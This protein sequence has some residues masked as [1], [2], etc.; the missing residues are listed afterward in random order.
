MTNKDPKHWQR[1]NELFD[2]I[3]DLPDH[4]RPAKLHQI[5]G[6]Y[7]D[8]IDDLCALIGAHDKAE[9]FLEQPMAV[10]S[11]TALSSMILRP[12][13]AP[14]LFEAGE[15][16]GDFEIKSVL[17]EGS[18][19][20]VYKAVQKSLARE[21]A[22]KVAGA[23]DREA[24]NMAS[25]EHDHIV[26]VFLETKYPEQNLHI[27]CMQYVEGITLAD[28]IKGLKK[29]LPG[30]LTGASIIQIIDQSLP[31]ATTFNAAAAKDRDKMMEASFWGSALWIGARLAE[32]LDFAHSR[33]VLH[34]D[35]KPANI[36]LNQYGRPLLTDFNIALNLADGPVDKLVLL[37]GT[38]AYMSPEQSA[39]FRTGGGS[40][41]QVSHTSDIYS[42]GIVLTELL[43]CEKAV[44][45]VDSVTGIRSI[46]N[47]SVLPDEI[48]S[49]LHKAIMKD[50]A[51]RFQS[52]KQFA[53]ALE[54]CR[55]LLALRNKV[56]TDSWWIKYYEMYPVFTLVLATIIPQI[57][58]T[59]INITYNSIRIAAGLTDRQQEV[60]H[61]TILPY[62]LLVYPIGIA[63]VAR[64]IYF[65]IHS[66][67]IRRDRL[68]PDPASM[69]NLRQRALSSP[70][71]LFAACSIGWLP[72]AIIFPMVIDFRAGPI[73]D[74][75]YWHY[76]ISFVTSWL[77][78]L[79]YSYFMLELILIVMLYPK[80]WTGCCNIA[81]SSASELAQVRSRMKMFQMLAG[82]IPLFGALM[83]V[84]SSS[85][86]MDAERYRIFQIMIIALIAMAICGFVIAI[87][88]SEKISAVISLYEKSNK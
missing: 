30:K 72:G 57:L 74:E 15:S 54:N 84:G 21:V 64:Q 28:L 77:V 5:A 23:A 38:L 13:T 7:P 61:D 87:K 4:D 85:A 24:R 17:G 79:T 40:S 58:G 18:F 11:P 36:L 52:G 3:V 75:V 27:I 68:L 46:T 70:K 69:A 76:A 26:R 56:Q 25:L 44:I 81:A 65:L 49:V 6:L 2:Q 59:L 80:F 83:I 1:I 39:A 32:A 86:S 67:K 42:L 45:E 16:I 22:I 10:V 8:L 60:F 37:G 33:R 82:A 20:R 71:Y 12:A 55:Q 50:P 63:I 29:M 53:D 88:T 47:T 41:A 34:L 19:A 51:D 43:I 9:K 66:I 78:A 14:R 48:S 35:V 31:G 73:M 62:N